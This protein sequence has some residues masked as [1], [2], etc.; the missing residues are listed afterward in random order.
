VKNALSAE[1]IGQKGD[2]SQGLAIFPPIKPYTGPE[3]S[4]FWLSVV[5]VAIRPID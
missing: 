2:P 4:C 5:P 1:I 3:L